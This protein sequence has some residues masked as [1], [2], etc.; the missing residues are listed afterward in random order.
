MGGT[1]VK[2]VTP[3]VKTSHGILVAQSTAFE[4]ISLLCGFIQYILGN[5]VAL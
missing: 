1:K 2:I 4:D 3:T 5:S